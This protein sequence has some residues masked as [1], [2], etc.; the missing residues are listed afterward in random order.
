MALLPSHFHPV[1]SD[2]GD[3]GDSVI[4]KLLSL[5]LLQ[6]T[7]HCS[8]VYNQ[9]NSW[10]VQTKQA[11]KFSLQTSALYLAFIIIILASDHCDHMTS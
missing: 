8:L 1:S 7:C 2:G 11:A 3:E 5:S 10:T 4:Q 6:H 9:H